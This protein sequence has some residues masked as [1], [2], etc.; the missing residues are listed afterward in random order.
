MLTLFLLFFT[1]CPLIDFLH[2]CLWEIE[3]WG[4]LSPNSVYQY[5]R[6]ALLKSAFKFNRFQEGWDTLKNHACGHANACGN[7]EAPLVWIVWLRFLKATVNTTH[8]VQSVLY[9]PCYKKLQCTYASL[10]LIKQRFQRHWL[11]VGANL[12]QI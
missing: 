8:Q 1:F 11:S 5:Q 7:L 2:T 9:E 12:R 10:P 6:K 4:I 3:I